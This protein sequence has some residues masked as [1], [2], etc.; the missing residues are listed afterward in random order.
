M[1]NDL[2]SPKGFLL[3]NNGQTLKR[4]ILFQQKF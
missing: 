1:L 3:G 4:F 2:P